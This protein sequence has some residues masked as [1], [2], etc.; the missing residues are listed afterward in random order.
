[1]NLK[2]LLTLLALLLTACASDSDKSSPP[3]DVQEN[4]QKILVESLGPSKSAGIVLNVTAP[5]WTWSSA[6]G[7][8]SLAPEEPAT[9]DMHFR[10]ASVSKTFAATSIMRLAQDGKLSIDDPIEKWLPR[11]Y[12][13]KIEDYKQMTL[14]M[15]LKC[16]TKYS[17][18]QA[19]QRPT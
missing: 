17:R 4:L 6:V 19:Y 18:V 14:R 5:E 3:L 15:L 8:A 9:S 2:F 11:K 1:M 7:S 10:I 16:G 12:L 13:D